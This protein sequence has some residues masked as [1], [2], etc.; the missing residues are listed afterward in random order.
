[1][2]SL[3]RA[4]WIVCQL[5]AR[6]HYAIP[7]ALYQRGL[8]ASLVTDVWSNPGSVS[9]VV[10]SRIRDRYHVGVPEHL[11]QASSW[12]FL[13]AEAGSRLARQRG[14]QAIMAR[15]ERFQRF[16]CK[17]L[18]GIA[19]A[20]GP[21]RPTLYAYSYAARRPLES[22]KRMGWRTVLGQIDGGQ[23]E[24]NL[25]ASCYREPADSNGNPR[26]PESY[27]DSWRAECSL[28]DHIVVNSEWSKDL[29][30]RAGVEPSKLTVIPLAYEAENGGRPPARDYPSQFDSQR[31]LRVLFLGQIGVRKGVPELLAASKILSDCPVE[32]W[33]VG[34]RVDDVERWGLLSG[35]V[36]WHAAV[37]RSGTAR[38]YKAADVFILPTHSD[39]FGLTQLEALANGLPVIASRN[40][41]RVV[42]EG[43]NGCFLNEVSGQ[44]I[45]DK[46]RH[47]LQNPGCLRAWS[48]N[49]VVGSMYSIQA[50][51]AQLA[52]LPEKS[53]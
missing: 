3:E 6:E 12:G 44:E 32:F 36:L 16:A 45:A 31:P 4:S 10:S 33:L 17:S 27:W 2:R 47:I 14:W 13:L 39:G 9:R 18:E 35:R 1:M 34:P 11:V 37:K 49:A 24:E 5:G 26:A 51:G 21:G 29:V 53:S 28:A 52:A 38:L 48:K 20:A 22:A 15:N 41:G 40:C 8:L 43:L 30:I 23:E 50:I 19:L 46:I 7:R 42:V 25:I